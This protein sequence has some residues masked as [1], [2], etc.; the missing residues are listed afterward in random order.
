MLFAVA[1]PKVLDRVIQ[2]V[3]A[4]PIIEIYEEK[5]NDFSYGFRPGRSCHDAIK[6]AL[7]YL[8]DGYEWV[9]DF[10]I[11]QF[12]DEVN[13]DK[14]IQILR[15]QMK[16][17]TT[18]N[19][20]RIYLKAGVMEKGLEK[21]IMTGVPQ[22]GPLEHST[23]HARFRCRYGHGPPTRS[24]SPCPHHYPPQCFRFPCTNRDGTTIFTL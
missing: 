24:Q 20:I 6:Q 12:F 17:S 16:D 2:Q 23:G 18:L 1:V 7:Y 19:L 13:H 15:E 22:G 21:A 14:L 8:N 3:V 4:K 5:F 11:E 10:N 9:I